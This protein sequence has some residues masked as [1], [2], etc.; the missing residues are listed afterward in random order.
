MAEITELS[1]LYEI[2]SV[3]FT[4]SFDSEKNLVQEISE[5][6]I[7]LLGIRSFALINEDKRG[8]ERVLT[9]WGFINT[10]E[11]T[12]KLNQNK[13]NQ[14]HFSFSIN[15]KKYTL[16]MEHVYPIKEKEKKLYLIFGQQVKNALLIAGNIAKLKWTEDRLT[17]INNCFC[18]FGPDYRKNIRHLTELCGNILNGACAIYKY[19]NDNIVSVG[20]HWNL[21][22]D[23]ISVPEPENHICY[24]ILKINENQIFNIRNL[25]NTPYAQKDPN[26]IRCQWQTCV[27]K[28]V[29]CK[30]NF[31]GAICVFYQKD[32]IL[33]EEDEK[34]LEIIIS[35]IR[36]EEEHYLTEKALK[37]SNEQLV[38]AQKMEAVGRLAG[39]IAH[40]FNNLLTAI[41]GYSE[42]LLAN[43]QDDN[44]CREDI[45]EIKK[46][47]DRGASL[48]KQLLAF[49]R[50]QAIQPQIVNLNTVITD[51]DKML[52]RLIGE[53]IELRLF[54]NPDIINIKVDPGQIGQMIV[55][56]AINALD[57]MPEGGKLIIETNNV[58]LDESYISEHLTAKPG[59]YV[60]LAVSDTGCGMDAET[61]SHIF[62]PFFT[63]KEK[64]K[65]TGLGLATIYGIVK[66]HNG[67]IYVYSEAGKGTV[68][69]IYLPQFKE[70]IVPEQEQKTL[71]SMR[72]EETILVVEDEDSIR[73]LIDKILKK[74]GYRVL[75][76]NNGTEAISICEQ[77]KE[78][79]HLMLVDV[80]LPEIKGT[81]LAKRL[82]IIKP[83]MKLLFMSGYT[84]S[85]IIDY[86]LLSKE[87]PFIQK[88]FT[89]DI[90]AKKIREVL[91][92]K[93]H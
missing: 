31:I 83:E 86:D 48:T 68:F 14:F 33:N 51:M 37:R 42:L 82:L 20:A 93:V 59:D 78:P 53:N 8:P 76:A 17:K 13:P 46:A 66:Q 34:F 62:E 67:H 22:S 29:K 30:N 55:N 56:L 77:Y 80:G 21:P 26:I 3:S 44:S 69:K 72:N 23:Y 64:D 6:A 61:Q 49:S 5:K 32:F 43:I 39:G 54:L 89:P 74:N 45:E 4:A 18:N 85:H 50:K 65:G 70:N 63:T 24:N 57:A 58:K 38:Q 15:N 36:I 73:I 16:F 88:P 84:D 87:S 7:S 52:K 91:N 75:T 2:A 9:S 19:F 1:M 11:L 71:Q 47:A 35:A 25:Q 12:E 90:L 28:A 60:M 10:D 92:D 40:D 81:E 41:R 79:I 27:G